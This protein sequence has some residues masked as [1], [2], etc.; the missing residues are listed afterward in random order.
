MIK[1]MKFLATR[2]DIDYQIFLIQP[3]SSYLVSIMLSMPGFVCFNSCQTFPEQDV[4]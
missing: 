4:Q 1:R 2:R 3:L